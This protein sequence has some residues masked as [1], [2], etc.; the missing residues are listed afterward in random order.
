MKKALF[1]FLQCTWGI[2]QTF[3]GLILFLF[4]INKKHYWHRNAIVTEWYY[5][6]SVS[7]GLFLF[8]E[9]SRRTLGKSVKDIGGE[10]TDRYLIMH[11]YG[12]SIQ[13]LLLGPLYLPVV[14]LS[15]LIWCNVPYY[16]RKRRKNHLSYYSFWT[17]KW[18][19][20]LS[21]NVHQE[22]IMLK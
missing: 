14:G 16:E 18:A 12:H 10:K 3:A 11:E 9:V 6:G 15:S 19:N 5:S 21:E 1:V 13:S 4:N 8:V 7:L 20:E 22:R 17:E 2:L